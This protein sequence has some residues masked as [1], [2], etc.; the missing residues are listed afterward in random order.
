MGVKRRHHDQ[1]SHGQARLNLRIKPEQRELIGRAATWRA[2][3]AVADHLP[4]IMENT[5]LQP[6]VVEQG[7]RTMRPKLMANRSNPGL[8][9]TRL[10]CRADQRAK[11]MGSQ[12]AD[13][14]RASGHNSRINRP[15]T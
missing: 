2:I 3:L 7:R 13:C 6:Q 8:G 12:A 9:Q 4:K 15:D 5:S 11:L 10:A 1:G 14:I